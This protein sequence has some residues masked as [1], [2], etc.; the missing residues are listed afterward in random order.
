MSYITPEQFV[1]ELGYSEILIYSD[2]F[3]DSP[4]FS[5]STAKHIIRAKEYDLMPKQEANVDLDV[6]AGIPDRNV[7]F[8][9]KVGI[10]GTIKMDLAG[11]IYGGLEY[12]TARMF[13]HMR[14]A[15]AGIKDD[16]DLISPREDLLAEHPWFSLGSAYHGTFIRCLVN[17]FN[18][19]INEGDQPVELEFGVVGTSFDP[20]SAFTYQGMQSLL[21]QRLFNCII[22]R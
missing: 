4:D 3:S 9:D 1:A 13:D 10:E 15:Y 11:N 21:W 7:F 8:A 17:N 19:N 12:P 6:I 16:G 14:Q 18:L 20:T 22:Y 5:S 2:E